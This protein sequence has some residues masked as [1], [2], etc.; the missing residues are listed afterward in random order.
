MKEDELEQLRERIHELEEQLDEYES[1]APL[2]DMALPEPIQEL[3]E[4]RED[5]EAFLEDLEK[6]HENGKISTSEYEKIKDAN[7]EKLEDVKK[8]LVQEW[9][10]LEGAVEEGDVDKGP[11]E[12]ETGDEEGGAAEEMEDKEEEAGEGEGEEEEPVEE[13][14]EEA[15]EEPGDEEE[16][17]ED[18]SEYEEVLEGS[19]EDVKDA[20]NSRN[21]DAEKLLELER[22]GDAR[23]T[24]IEW[25]ESKTG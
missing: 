11:E 13:E 15:G 1:I 23:D 9:K 2:A 25:L 20:F 4:K 22:D 17:G 10:D 18:D 16:P 19:V 14:G 12:P 6:Q 8:Q 24:L 5:I 21:L 7:E 3:R